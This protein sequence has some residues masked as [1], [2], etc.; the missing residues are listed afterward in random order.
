MYT[1]HSAQGPAQ[2]KGLMCLQSC[3]AKLSV[4]TEK[5]GDTCTVHAGGSSHTEVAI[6]H[7]KYGKCNWGI[8]FLILYNYIKF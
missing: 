5:L 4:L 3:L 1:K 7:L 2:G 8:E 6:E